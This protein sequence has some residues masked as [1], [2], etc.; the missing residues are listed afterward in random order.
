MGKN[1]RYLKQLIKDLPEEDLLELQ[2]DMLANLGDDDDNKA[3]EM[4]LVLMSDF[5]GEAQERFKSFGRM[6]GLSTGYDRLDGL[7]MGLVGG[8]LV[9]VAGKTSRGKTT[10]ALN[11]ASRVAFSGKTVLFVTLEMTHSEI[12][13]RMMF[14]NDCTE[15]E[16]TDQ[17]HDIASKIV[18]QS[19]D[20]LRWDS[21]DKLM[22]KAKMEMGVDL[23]VIDHLHYFTRELQNISED[24][25]RITKEF[26]KNAARHNV[27]VILIS[28]VRKTGDDKEATMEDMR[29]SSYMA[30]DADIVLMVGR[31]DGD[32]NHTY[33]KID[34]NRNRGKP[35]D[36]GGIEE[37]NRIRLYTDRI[38]IMNEDPAGYSVPDFHQAAEKDDP[39][40][41]L[42]LDI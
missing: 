31:I 14:V 12:T 39:S 30:Q 17:Y 35:S 16:L 7:T 13:Q 19:T 11:I 21:I 37:D 25:G 41:E 42:D 29:G 32:V 8:E 40:L 33:V 38:K 28:H 22:E 18:F 20:E 26:K 34:K 23:V 5:T 36:R 9:M 6:Q 27:P 3:A 1:L 10:L 15:D 4:N 24:L 2:T